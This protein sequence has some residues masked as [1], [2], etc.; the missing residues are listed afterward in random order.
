MGEFGD[1]MLLALTSEAEALKLGK[2]CPSE[3][4]VM[5]V[6]ILALVITS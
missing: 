6:H 4:L 2:I 1:Q 5:F 3:Y